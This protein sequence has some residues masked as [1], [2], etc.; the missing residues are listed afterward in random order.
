MNE[1]SRVVELMILKAEET[2]N[3]VEGD[4]VGEDNLYYCGKCN[5]RKQT[6]VNILGKDRLVPCVCKCRADAIKAEEEERK[7]YEL[8]KEIMRMR[9]VAF[10]EEEMQ[11]WS[12]ANDDNANPLLTTAMKKYVENF[13]ALSKEGKGLL[14]FGDTGTG[15]SYLA[16]CVVNALIDKGVPCVMTNFKIIDRAMSES[17]EGRQRYFNTLVSQPLLV[18]DDLGAERKTEYM[19][20]I[21][22]DILDARSMSNKPIIV[23]TNLTREELL[24]PISMKEKRIFSRVFKL[25]TPIEVAGKDRRTEALR[26]GIGGVKKLL[27]LE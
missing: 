13:S 5:K 11:E 17:F 27:G 23:T 18:L 24:N 21:V 22:F 6:V 16:A 25:C 19:Q 7:R 4:Y 26:N 3:I 8:H 2:A 14:L 15:K 1:M 20:D 9:S 12:F 10:P